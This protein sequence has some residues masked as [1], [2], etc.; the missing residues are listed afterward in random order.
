MMP[1]VGKSKDAVR[2]KYCDPKHAACTVMYF[3]LSTRECNLFNQQQ[4]GGAKEE[5]ER[6]YDVK[7]VATIELESMDH[8]MS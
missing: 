3:T 7:R 2:T 5:L 4:L 1:K 8:A 6:S